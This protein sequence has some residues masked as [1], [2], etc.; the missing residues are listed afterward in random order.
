[1]VADGTMPK[2]HFRPMLG[3]TRK[4]K[5]S[6]IIIFLLDVEERQTIFFAIYDI[7]L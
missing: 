2:R 6:L 3:E 1:M 4:T 5:V 7:I